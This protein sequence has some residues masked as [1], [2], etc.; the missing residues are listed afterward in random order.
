[1]PD[2]DRSDPDLGNPANAWTHVVRHVG[3]GKS[4]LDLGCWD[5]LLLETLGGRG[6]RGV[7]VERDPAALGRARARGLEVVEA[8]LD[9]PSWPERLGGRR[10]DAVVMADVVEHVRE[11]E[12]VL[13]EASRCLAPGGALVLSVP[14]VAHAS[15]RLSLLLGDFDPVEKGI[16][17]RTHLHWFTLRSLHA[18]LRSAGLRIDELS[19]ST[20]DLPEEVA[21]KSL[22]RAGIA[23][24]AV[25]RWLATAPETETLQFVV[26]ARPAPLAEIPEAPPATARDPLRLLDRVFRTQRTKIL[27]LEERLAYLEKGKGFRTLRSLWIRLRQRRERR[28]QSRTP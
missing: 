9:D 28:G 13:A 2:Y 11:P 24:P 19:R 15:V 14:N 6:C 21:A 1:M 12:R 22:E 18:M 26:T 16:L 20:L 4:V 27:E 7:G 5:G 8:D 23:D 25:S 3:T 10:F 17:D